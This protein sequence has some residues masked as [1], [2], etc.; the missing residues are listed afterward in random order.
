MVLDLAGGEAS[1]VQRTGTS[2]LG[3]RR[4]PFDPARTA[5]LG[6]LDLPEPEQRAI[7]ARLG[8]EGERELSVPSW[9]HDVDGPADL[10][11]EVVRIMGLDRV[12]PAA[13]PRAHGKGTAPE[14]FDR[15][16]P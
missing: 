10:V 4:V 5:T 12:P 7:L 14:R 11:E 13:L 3:E 9:R 16:D 1:P 8:F 2:P 15:A 6:G